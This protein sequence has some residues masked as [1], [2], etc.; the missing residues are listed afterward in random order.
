MN[1][2]DHSSDD[3]PDSARISE[4]RRL[5]A[6]A[7]ML[8]EHP[9]MKADQGSGLYV[10]AFAQARLILYLVQESERCKDAEEFDVLQYLICCQAD[11]LAEALSL[12]R[13]P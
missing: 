10:A 6:Q 12:L 3:V 4:A 9:R 8:L 5:A 2:H 1:D 11:G 7:V 13:T